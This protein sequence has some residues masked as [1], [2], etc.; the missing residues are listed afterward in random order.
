MRPAIILFA[1]APVA[2][3]VKTRLQGTLGMEAT[4]ELHQAFVLDMLDKLLTLSAVADIELHTDIRT[5]VWRRP[6]V[7][8]REQQPGDLGLKMFHAIAGALAQGRPQVCIAGSDA[9]ALPVTHLEALLANSADVALGPCDDGGY[10]AI[11][12]RRSHPEMFRGVEWSSAQALVQTEAAAENC[13]L[14]VSRGPGWW[15]VDQPSDLARL[16]REGQAPPHTTAW[17][18]RYPIADIVLADLS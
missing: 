15:D 2:G 9:P 18:K 7:T 16:I 6:E 13:G 11:A 14:R 10:Y 4:L 12:C 1:K 5:D 3:H 17:L 8:H